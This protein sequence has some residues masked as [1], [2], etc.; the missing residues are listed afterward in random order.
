M[1]NT[2]QQQMLVSTKQGQQVIQSKENRNMMYTLEWWR[3]KRIHKF[4]ETA[5]IYC[6]SNAS[7]Q[8]SVYSHSPYFS[9]FSYKPHC[10]ERQMINLNFLSPLLCAT[11]RDT[12]LLSIMSSDTSKQLV[13]N[14]IKW[15][16]ASSSQ[17]F[18]NQSLVYSINNE[19][20]QV[21]S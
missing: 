1:E 21:K 10:E 5:K 13:Y 2:K 20:C 7:K 6:G 19:G 3:F 18:I 8:S 4:Y 12:A 14:C 9:I 17:Q 16:D 11:H 15:I